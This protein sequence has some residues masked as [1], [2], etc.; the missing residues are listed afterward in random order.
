MVTSVTFS[1]STST[2]PE[3][4]PCFI[5]PDLGPNAT[6]VCPPSWTSPRPWR[7][8]AGIEPAAGWEGTALTDDAPTRRPHVLT[9]TFFAGNCLFDHR[10]IYFGVRTRD[11]H[12]LWKEYRDPGDAFSPEGHELYDVG[13]DP[14]ESNNIYRPD[15]PLVPGF[16]AVIA[17]RLAELP[18]ITDERIIALFG[19]EIAADVLPVADTFSPV[20]KLAVSNIALSAYDHA[21]ELGRLTDLGLSGVEVAP[22]RVWRDTWHG[23]TPALVAAYRRD[24]EAAGLGV[25]GLHS[26]FYDHPELGLFRDAETRARSLDF[27]VHLSAVCRDL[28]GRTLIWGGGRRLGDVGQAPARAEAQAFMAELCRRI[29]GHGTVFCFE[30]LGPDETDFINSAFDALAIVAAVDH[31]ALR[32]QLDA[33]ALVANGRGDGRALPRRGAPPGPLS[34]QRARSRRA[35]HQRRCRSP[36]VGR[37]LA[38]Y[39][40]PGVRFDRATDA[41]RRSPRGRRGPERPRPHGLL[42]MTGDRP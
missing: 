19:P 14:G 42:P 37:I 15:H 29:E 5:G 12:Y 17:R 10:P 23:L 18:E 41:Q 34:R 20:P 3:F 24:V 30:P 4:R 2:T 7:P 36:G 26:L 31:P 35:R 33:K 32:M 6:K 8:L 22:S 16:N 1:C 27:L 38:R 13:A 9:E 21:A 39:R 11:H 28:G 25:V 40:L